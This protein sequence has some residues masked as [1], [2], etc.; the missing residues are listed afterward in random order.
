MI[1][2]RHG[3]LAVNP[4]ALGAD[5]V[6]PTQ[7]PAGNGDVGLPGISVAIVPIRGPL[8]SSPVS[9]CDDYESI[10]ARVAQACATDAECVVLDIDSPGGSVTGL[11]DACAEIRAICAESGKRLLAYVS[12]QCC[13]AAYALACAAESITACST[14]MVGS[15]GVVDCRV[16]F[17]AANAAH[18]IRY[19][20]VCSGARKV[21]GHPG[22]AITDGEVAARQRTVDELAAVFFVHVKAS[23]G[24]DAAPLQ[25][26]V[27]V[28]ESAKSAGLV[29]GVLGYREFLSS[30]AIEPTREPMTYEE[31][32]AALAAMAEGDGPD[33]ELAKAAL[34]RLSEESPAMT[35]ESAMD[36]EP[37]P[38]ASTV[39]QLAGQVQ[40]LSAQLRELAA[41]HEAS[42]LRSLLASRADLGPELIGVLSTKSLAEAKAIL[43]AMPRKA[44]ALTVQPANP[45]LGEGQATAQASSGEYD[46]LDALMGIGAQKSTGVVRT[47][48]SLIL[49]APRKGV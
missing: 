35:D 41:A 16:D 24:L 4:S 5:F 6:R 18:G 29:D 26:A 9:H 7:A 34:A 40:S 10:V 13:S 12:G 2:A 30:I 21:D 23:R 37:E 38:E 49:G 28:G 42:S 14:G 20:M 1:Y 36:E 31:L 15:I 47:D 43:A 27:Y 25:A 17:S 44:R 22:V 48:H 45:T 3:L 8:D 39:A 46:R 19:S 32:M 11:F 33:A